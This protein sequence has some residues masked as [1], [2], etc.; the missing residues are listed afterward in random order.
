MGPADVADQFFDEVLSQSIPD[1]D[2][3]KKEVDEVIDPGEVEKLLKDET[4]DEGDDDDKVDEASGEATGEPQA[5]EHVPREVEVQEET[6]LLDSEGMVANF[7]Q[8]KRPTM[9]SKLHLSAGGN[10]GTTVEAVPRCGAAGSYDY[11]GS[12]EALA[13]PLCIRCFGRP[14]AC[15]FLCSIKMKI[16]EPV[17]LQCAR[18]CACEG[19]HSEHLCH[20]HQR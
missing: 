1:A 10:K 16:G 3:I 19:E 14:K 4:A 9:L 20:L 12:I 11:V 5:L 13:S 17:P 15:D 6:D 2:A 8:V 7:V 18:R